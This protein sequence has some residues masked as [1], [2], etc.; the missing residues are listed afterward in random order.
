MH[1]WWRCWPRPVPWRSKYL[2]RVGQAWRSVRVPT[3][4]IVTIAMATPPVDLA[5]MFGYNGAARFVG[6]CGHNTPGTVAVTDGATKGTSGWNAA[7]Q[8]FTEH[9][10]IRPYL[11][12]FQVGEGGRAP[13]HMLVID[14][15]SNS[16]SVV[17]YGD[18]SEYLCTRNHGCESFMPTSGATTIDDL[19]Q[20]AH[21][22]QT[23]EAWLA[24][25]GVAP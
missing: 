23:L 11:A 19:W 22:L 7:W 17:E 24:E 25:R 10:S 15:R 8:I 3:R 13:A 21:D 2:W 16:V 20:H 18:A 6:V 9:P 12:G 14:R 1:Q 5:R 4:P